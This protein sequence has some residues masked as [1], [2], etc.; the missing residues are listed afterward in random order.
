MLAVG[1]AWKLPIDISTHGGG[2]DKLIIWVH[3]FMA[4]LFVGWGVYLVYCLVR[5]RSRANPEPSTELPKAKASKYCEVAIVIVEAILL[6][7]FS[8]PIWASVR[9]PAGVPE[10]DPENRLEVRIV[11]KQFDWTIHYPGRDGK[12]GPSDPELI[13]RDDIIGLDR[14]DPDG[15]DDIITTN[16][17]HIPVNKDILVHLTSMD[18]IHSFNLPFLRIK[19]DIIPGMAIPVWFKAKMTT[20]DVRREMT[21]TYSTRPRKAIMLKNHQAM[22]DYKSR[23]GTAIVPKG[24][25]LNDESIQA[26]YDAGIVEILAAPSVPTEIACA[27]LCGL[28]HYRMRG[29]LHIETEEDF[30]AW[31]TEQEAELDEESY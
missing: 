25:D 9:G 13:T 5:F 26:L 10:P 29:Y 27:Q 4:V 31:L 2:I 11:A 8:V 30:D 17:F 3:L 22:D 6:L 12:F 1:Y 20:D 18:V 28:G 19:Q 7:V 21:R 23:D 24:D 16:Q 14:D 15:Q